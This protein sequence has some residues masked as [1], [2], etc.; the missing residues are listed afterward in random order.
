DAAGRSARGGRPGVAVAAHAADPR[1]QDRARRVDRARDPRGAEPPG[2]ADDRRGRAA[3]APPDPRGHRTLRA[4]WTCPGRV[5]RDRCI[6]WPVGRA[7][8]KRKATIFK[9]M[10]RVGKQFTKVGKEIAIAVKAGGP[11]PDGNPTL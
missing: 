6:G 4:R 1:P 2:P 8:E 5:A 10:D 7:F 11:S 3:D 9:R